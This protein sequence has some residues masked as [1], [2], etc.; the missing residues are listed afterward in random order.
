MFD[1]DNAHVHYIE[2][3]HLTDVI[4]RF[5]GQCT[6]CLDIIMKTNLATSSLCQS[7]AERLSCE[8]D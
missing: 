6:V 2:V 3:Q 8:L 1:I 5:F 7:V 4:I